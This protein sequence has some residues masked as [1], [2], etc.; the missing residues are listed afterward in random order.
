MSAR[1][2]GRYVR[3]P[4]TGE[5]RRTDDLPASA[6]GGVQ[7]EGNEAAPAKRPKARADKE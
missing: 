5:T 2:G 4:A 3:D 7:P 1:K 6:P